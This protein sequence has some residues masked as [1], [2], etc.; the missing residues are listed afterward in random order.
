L[1][2]PPP[3]RKPAAGSKTTTGEKVEVPKA[4][5]RDTLT[6]TEFVPPSMTET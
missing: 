5:P 3:V 6:L 4:L 1:N 2:Q